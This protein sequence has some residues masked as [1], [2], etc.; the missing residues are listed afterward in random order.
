MRQAFDWERVPQ[1]LDA[2]L[3]AESILAMEFPD[4]DLPRARR[5]YSK[6]RSRARER[7]IAFTFDFDE[8]L[9]WWLVDGRW[10]RRGRGGDRLCMCRLG[11][12][13]LPMPT[14]TSTPRPFAKTAARPVPSCRYRLMAATHRRGGEGLASQSPGGGRYCAHPDQRARFIELPGL[15]ANDTEAP[16]EA[17]HSGTRLP[18]G[19]SSVLRRQ[20]PS[21]TPKEFRNARGLSLNALLTIRRKADGRLSTGRPTGVSWPRNGSRTAN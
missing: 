5:A 17:G 13:G 8:W 12:R 2:R 18:P 6:Q 11:D 15:Q 3:F 9:E 14:G 21:S 19:T 10:E 1:T 16:D 7:G 4:T 20:A